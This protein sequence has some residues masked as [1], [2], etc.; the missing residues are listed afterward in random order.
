MAS[1]TISNYTCLPPDEAFMRDYLVSHGPLSVALDARF[2]MLYTGGISNPPMC[3]SEELDHAVLLVGYGSEVPPPQPPPNATA[4]T[5]VAAAGG[6]GARDA[7]D[8]WLVKNSWTEAWGEKGYF[9]LARGA[10]TCGAPPLRGAAAALPSP[11]RCCGGGLR[12][13]VALAPRPP[14][15][16]RHRQRGVERDPHHP[17]EPAH[18]LRQ[19]QAAGDAR[20]GGGGGEARRGARHLLRPEDH[21]GDAQAGACSGWGRHELRSTRTGGPFAPPA[22]SS[23]TA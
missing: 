19:G 14:L 13:R 9:R 6:A 16:R 15:S 18:A 4:G 21:L 20:P 23:V 8:F 12:E 3:S 5:Q 17:H 7:V 10:N 2:L 11:V 22:P 1:A